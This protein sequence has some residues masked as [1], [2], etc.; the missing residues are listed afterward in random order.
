MMVNGWVSWRLAL[1]TTDTT[2]EDSHPRHGA[3]LPPVHAPLAATVERSPAND[4]H[5][6]A[7]TC[8]CLGLGAEQALRLRE[9][10]LES[11]DL[12]LLCLEAVTTADAA[13]GRCR[14]N[15]LRADMRPA[16]LS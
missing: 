6:R 2:Q 16:G 4:H 12:R 5:T 10:R 8:T 15:H 3:L 11:R 1:R 7:C 9:P 14:D 13:T